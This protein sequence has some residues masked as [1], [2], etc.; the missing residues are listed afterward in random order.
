MTRKELVK[1][2]DN[3]G[4]K[5]GDEVKMLLVDEADRRRPPLKL[6]IYHAMDKMLFIIF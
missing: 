2:L 3:A 4:I 5:D 6:D 1:H